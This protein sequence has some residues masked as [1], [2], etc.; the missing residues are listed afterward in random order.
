M[1][2]TSASSRHL[3]GSA[4]LQRSMVVAHV[5]VKA[6]TMAL[7]RGIRLRFGEFEELCHVNRRHSDSWRPVIPMFDVTHCR[8][9]PDRSFA[10]F[11]ETQ[12]GEIAVTACARLY[13]WDDRSLA[14]EVVSL[15]MFYDDPSA[16]IQRGERWSVVSPEVEQ[17]RGRVLFTGGAWVRP[18]YR[19]TGLSRI[20]PRFARAY[21]LNTWNPDVI[22]SFQELSMA[23]G[24][25]LAKSGHV[26]VGHAV[27]AIDSPIGSLD[28]ALGKMSPADLVD[29][30]QRFVGTSAPGRA[31]GQ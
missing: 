10:V 27:T 20:V 14:D 28:I 31:A 24:G 21:G 8:L 17:V 29:D 23:T 22:C 11:G 9:A 1:A 13:E 12:D 2:N 4:I 30:L 26:N 5:L 25:H 15:R 3:S 19:S 18:D 16:A 6:Y 7:D